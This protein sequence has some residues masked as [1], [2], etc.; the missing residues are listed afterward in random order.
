MPAFLGN[1][2]ADEIEEL[3]TKK[4]RCGPHHCHYLPI[5]LQIVDRA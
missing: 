2:T 3:R 5:V 4:R 1:L